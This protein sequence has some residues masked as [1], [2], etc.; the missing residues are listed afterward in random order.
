M[1]SK[2]I[3]AVAAVAILVVAGA[4]VVLI[5]N[6]DESSSNKISNSEYYKNGITVNN[7]IDS[8]TDDSLVTLYDV[9]KIFC[10]YAQNIELMCALGCEDLIVG[11]YITTDRGTASINPQYQEAF[12]KVLNKKDSNGEY[13]IKEAASNA[14]SKEYALASGA[15]L[16]IGWASTFADSLLGT[17]DYWKP[18][19]V[20]IFKTN[21]YGNGTGTS[22]ETYYQLLDT[23]GTLLNSKEAAQKNID[24]W[25]N[26]IETINSKVSKL[27][28]SKK[29][30]VLVIDYSANWYNG[31]NTFV[32]GTSMLTGC[33]VEAAGAD[34]IDTGRMTKH[35][36]EEISHMDFN[37]VLT[38]GEPK[39]MTTAEWWNSQPVLKEMGI[40]DSRIKSLPFNILYMSGILKEDVLDTLFSM[41]YPELAGTA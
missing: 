34:D 30:K 16:L 4:G 41:F 5:N 27:D 20:Q 17:A 35:T 36:I 9:P 38:V 29:V 22:M 3:V 11:G 7:R 12:Q 13:I 31:G 40:D 39:D 23:M 18:F 37:F 21:I 8:S 2:M 1:N 26:K 28:D 14:W 33:L 24:M 19:G 6:N 15:N 25:K 32:Y 10:I